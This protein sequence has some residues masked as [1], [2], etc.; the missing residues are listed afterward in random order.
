VLFDYEQCVPLSNA[1]QIAG[2]IERSR[3]PLL[4]NMMRVA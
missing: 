3:M 2:R 1:H 4:G